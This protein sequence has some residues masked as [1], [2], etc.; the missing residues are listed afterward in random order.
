MHA[1]DEN[2]KLLKFETIQAFI[3]HY[4]QVR[5]AFYVKRKAQQ[6]I[7]LEKE[8][9]VL[10][11]KAR[12]IS[13]LL[14]DSLDLRKKKTSV[15]SALLKERNYA[16]VDEDLDYKYLVRLPMD[17]V[18]EENATKI[19]Q[20]RDRKQSELATLTGTTE[21]DLW[22]NELATLRTEYMKKKSTTEKKEKTAE[23]PK[24]KLKLAKA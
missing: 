18:T 24:K 4:M 3:A 7:G 11:N 9:Q 20:E 17:S 15:V 12:F 1:F 6:M 16:V 14:D 8:T 10:S 13:E 22:L 2:E 5:M 21:Q 19:M 23:V